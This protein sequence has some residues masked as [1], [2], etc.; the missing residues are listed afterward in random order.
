MVWLSG[1]EFWST[2]RDTG[3]DGILQCFLIFYISIFVCFFKEINLFF[4][5]GY[6][7]CRILLFS[8]KPQHESVTGI[9]IS[10]PFWNSVLLLEYT[11]FGGEDSSVV[12]LLGRYKF[13]SISVSSLRLF[14]N[15][16]L[17]CFFVPRRHDGFGDLGILR[18]NESLENT[19]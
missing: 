9:H 16:D 17:Y 19:S 7:L 8:V 12:I 3:S 4:I 15:R 1:C 14:D 13:K 18:V 10:P 5:E 2:V 6:L 11:T